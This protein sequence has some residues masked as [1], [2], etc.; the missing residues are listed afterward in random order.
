MPVSKPEQVKEIELT[1]NRTLRPRPPAF[2]N[3]PED[4]YNI[5]SILDSAADISFSLVLLPEPRLV[6]ILYPAFVVCGF[7]D[8]SYG[9]GG[10][11]ALF[12]V[13]SDPL[14]TIVFSD[15]LFHT[16]VVND[17]TQELKNIQSESQASR[18]P[19]HFHSRIYSNKRFCNITTTTGGQGVLGSSQIVGCG[20]V[21]DWSPTNTHTNCDIN[22]NPTGFIPFQD[23]PIRLFW[24]YWK[25]SGN[26]GEVAYRVSLR[27]KK[28]IILFCCFFFFF[29]V[30][31]LLLF[32][33]W[34][35]SSTTFNV[36]M[37]GAI[38]YF[39]MPRNSPLDHVLGG[40]IGRGVE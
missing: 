9:G 34:T 20:G 39:F 38:Q 37:L 21:F 7:N 30:L 12:P 29:L 4:P 13:T 22:E 23:P 10:Y 3:L 33:F 40:R 31:L 32:Y 17:V 5:L 1:R 27:R 15:F 36:G 26:S 11:L 14:I 18:P 25:K 28:E 24:D 8:D 19:L 6:W 2:P 35:S 16:M